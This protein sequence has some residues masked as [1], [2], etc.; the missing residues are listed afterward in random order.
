MSDLV[1]VADSQRADTVSVTRLTMEA[2]VRNFVDVTSKPIPRQARQEP[3]PII[4][5]SFIRWG[6]RTEFQVHEFRVQARVIKYVAPEEDPEPERRKRYLYSAS[7]AH[8]D[9]VFFHVEKTTYL[10]VVIDGDF[11]IDKII[12]QYDLEQYVVVRDY[13]SL[14]LRTQEALKG[15]HGAPNQPAEARLHLHKPRVVAPDG[16]DS[17]EEPGFPA[18]GQ[19]DERP[20]WLAWKGRHSGPFSLP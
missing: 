7:R 2:L 1:V 17:G 4:P 9:R 10:G 8:V 13:I 5:K 3:A 15:F 11:T 19:L 14:T 6:A 12:Q 18:L 20:E 16:P